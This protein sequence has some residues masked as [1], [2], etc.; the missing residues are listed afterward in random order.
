MTGAELRIGDE[1][2]SKAGGQ[3][4]TLRDINVKESKTN[5][6]EMKLEP[7]IRRRN[8]VQGLGQ[9][10]GGSSVQRCCRACRIWEEVSQTPGLGFVEQRQRDDTAQEAFPPPVVF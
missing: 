9:W 10:T 4:Q 8:K 5:H 1:G 6:V 7:I 2:Q 3:G